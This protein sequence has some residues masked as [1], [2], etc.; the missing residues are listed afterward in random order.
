[1]VLRQALLFLSRH[2][3]LEDYL[4][5]NALVRQACSRFVPATSRGDV[6]ALARRMAGEGVGVSFHFLGDTINEPEQV[7]AT[8]EE[9]QNLLDELANQDLDAGLAVHPTQLGL[10]ISEELAARNLLLLARKAHENNRR[11]RVNMEGSELT[12]R[13]LSLVRGAFVQSSNICTV[14][15]SY[16]ARSS[17]D[18]EILNKEKIPVTLV[19]GAYLEPAEGAFK[20]QEEVV[21]YFMRLIETLLRDG[22]Q[23]AIAT[24]DEKLI[25]FAIDIAFIFGL[26]EKDYEF[27]MLYGIRPGLQKKLLQQGYRLRI[28]LPYG[29]NWYPYLMRRLA[30]R[31]SN[32]WKLMRKDRPKKGVELTGDPTGPP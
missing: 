3:E 20:D 25:E 5:D 24:H 23:P 17:E 8:V 14:V 11:I 22:H 18:I 6:M 1:M 27:Q 2:R 12:A 7:Q 9:Y 16:L 26:N 13:V 32:L 21:L 15:Q 4:K 29:P 19:K 28:T 30:E 31:P 10:G